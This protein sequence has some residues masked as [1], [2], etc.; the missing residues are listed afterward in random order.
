MTV[1]EL[2]LTIKNILSQ[3]GVSDPSFEASYLMEEI[4][5]YDRNKIIV[6]GDDV[7]SDHEKEKLLNMAKKRAA[8]EPLQYVMGLWYFMDLPFAVG[9]GVL[10]PREDT[11]VCVDI[12]IKRIK[13][14]PEKEIQVLDLCAGSGAISVAISKYCKN[15]K[16]TAVE[17]SPEAYEYL[18]KN[19]YINQADVKAVKCD[20]FYPE[21]FL[22]DEEFDI[23]VSNPPYI[24]REELPTLQSEVQYEPKMA[25][26]GGESGLDFYSFITKRYTEFLK[27][28]GMLVYELGE[29]QFEDVKKMMTDAGFGN[30]SSSLDIGGVERAISG[31]Y[32]NN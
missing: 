2:Y 23:I 3:G 28:D 18:L 12:C 24:K 11:Q 25:L 13:E 14:N 8:G 9:K 19:I 29:D 10:I 4:A 7:I 27:K 5:G 22:Q 31:F 16:V 30:I 26:D 1:K 6:Y 32:K 17:K 15:A 20:I 21:N